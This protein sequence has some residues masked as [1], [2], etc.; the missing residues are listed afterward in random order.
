MLTAVP[1]G[2]GSNHGEDMDVCKYIVPS[3]H[4]CSFN[5]RRAASL[6]VRLVEGEERWEVPDHP[7]GVLP[8]IWSEAEL[9]IILST[10]WC[11][12]LW[13]TTRVT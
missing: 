10:A 1:L 3:R 9:K 4:D 6:L 13:L 5:K 8:Q 12:K 11:S 2:L 7:Q